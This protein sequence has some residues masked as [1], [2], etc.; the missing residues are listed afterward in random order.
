VAV[1]SLAV[2]AETVW[3]LKASSF[4]ETLGIKV[5]VRLEVR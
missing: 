5:P 2:I 3:L 1:E 4:L